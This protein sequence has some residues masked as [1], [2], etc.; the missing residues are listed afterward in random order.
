MVIIFFI[1]LLVYEA[2]D[3]DKFIPNFNLPVNKKKFILKIYALAWDMNHV[4]MLLVF[5]FISNHPVVEE[6]HGVQLRTVVIDKQSVLPSV[7]PF[8]C[9]VPL[10]SLKSML[11]WPL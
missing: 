5:D 10:L 1:L 11:S 9:V 6:Y 3:K 7:C 2:E 4:I 8:N